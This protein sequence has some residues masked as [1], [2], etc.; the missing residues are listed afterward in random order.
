[1]SPNFTF[2]VHGKRRLG[3]S[4]FIL[5]PQKSL[6]LSNHVLIQTSVTSS[7]LIGQNY[8]LDFSLVPQYCV[9]FLSLNWFALSPSK[10]CPFLPLKP[11]S[12][13]CSQSPLKGQGKRRTRHR[14]KPLQLNLRAHNSRAVAN[15]WSRTPSQCTRVDVQ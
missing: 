11:V 8:L 10:S 2:F 9:Y 12:A 6:A 1:M 13:A 4:A 3:F 5:A 7:M 15:L 14:T